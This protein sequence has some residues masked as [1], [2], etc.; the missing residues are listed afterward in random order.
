MAGPNKNALVTGAS[1]RIGK[2]LALGLAAQ[3]WT[4]A[5][6]YKSSARDAESVVAEIEDNGGRAVA[7]KADLSSENDI[8]Q[9]V[10]RVQDLL[11]PV[12]CL[13]NNASVFERDEALTATRDSWD[14]H[15]DVNLRAPFVL[16][17]A[18]A[19]QLP[20]SD[21]GVVINM[22]DQRVWALTPDFTSYTLSKAALWTLTRTL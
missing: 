15:L 13:I 3:G 19:R 17:Q 20:A 11:G 6:H 4:V 22:I 12:T 1:G 16:T 9:L 8:N 10:P 5:V 21:N 14:L 7:V 18:L 2:A